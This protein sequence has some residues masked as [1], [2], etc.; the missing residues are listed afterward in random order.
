MGRDIWVVGST[1]V[2]GVLKAVVCPVLSMLRQI[3]K[4]LIN[5]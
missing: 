2:T 4:D 5:G 1:P 3:G